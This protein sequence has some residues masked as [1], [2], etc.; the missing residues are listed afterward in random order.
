MLFRSS[1]ALMPKGAILP[2]GD[3]PTPSFFF[4]PTAPLV[5]E[6]VL[7]DASASCPGAPGCPFGSIVSYNWNFSD[8]NPDSGKAVRHVFT[9][10]QKYDVTLTVTT[11]RGLAA[12]LTQPVT[13]TS[14]NPIPKVV[15]SPAT[16]KA[17]QGVIFDAS[18]TEVFGGATIVSY[19]WTFSGGIP[20]SSTSGPIAGPI[21]FQN[22]G[23]FNLTVVDSAGRQ[24][25]TSGVVV[26]Q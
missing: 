20:A 16:P 23:S 19:Q 1:I 2:P 5:N 3:P 10:A 13:V 24:G 9:R 17:G 22:S 11:D 21:T 12:M 8:G 6:S 14:G 15:L 26:V 25:S 18:G 7:F 4:F